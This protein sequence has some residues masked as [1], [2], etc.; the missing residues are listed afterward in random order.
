MPE[1]IIDSSDSLLAPQT[2]T[3]AYFKP[4]GVFQGPAFAGHAPLQL[5][6]CARPPLAHKQAKPFCPSLY[7]I[8]YLNI[9]TT[10]LEIILGK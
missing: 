1:A 6:Y 8:N 5:R 3:V 9:R 4:H 10:E 7:F 2:G